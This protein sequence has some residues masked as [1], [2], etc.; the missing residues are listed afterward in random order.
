M[1]SALVVI[2]D[3]PLA[4]IVGISTALALIQPIGDVQKYLE[5]R[6]PQPFHHG[7][8]CLWI[9]LTE[10]VRE[11]TEALERAV[12]S[13]YSL[14]FS[15]SKVQPACVRAFELHWKA[16]RK[17]GWKLRTFRNTYDQWAKSQDWV[18]LVN[19]SKAPVSWRETNVGLSEEFLRKAVAVYFKKYNRKDGKRQAVFAIHRWWRTGRDVYGDERPVPGYESGWD[20]RNPEL[21]PSGWDYSNILRQV[22]ERALFTEPVR[23]LVHQ[24]TAA[25]KDE[26]PQHP[27]TRE[28]LLFLQEVTFDDVRTDFLIMD[29]VTGQPCELWLLVA[30]DTATAMVLGFVPHP[31]RARED[32]SDSHLGHLEMK[33]LVGFL[34]ER[35]PLPTYLCEWKVER[36][37]ATLPAGMKAALQEMLPNNIVV[38]YT[39]MIGGTSPNGYRESRKG[40][41]R[42][43][44]SHESHN[45]L[46]HTQSCYLD[47]QTGSNYALRPA[48]LKARCEEAVEIWE[49]SKLLPVHLRSEVKYP[50]LDL[51]QACEHLFR[52]SV[53]QNF[54]TNH[55]L[56]NFD[57][58]VEWF[59]PSEGQ[60]GKWKHQSTFDVTKHNGSKIRTRKRMEMPVERA[61]RLMQGHEWRR[62]S[63]DIIIALYRHT[64]SKLK[65]KASGE[66]LC[67]QILYSPPSPELRPPV[68]AIGYSHP[69]DPQFLHV[70]DGKGVILG[71][72]VRRDRIQKRDQQ[73]LQ[74]AMR[75]T[76][77]ALKAVQQYADELAAPDVERLDAMRVHNELVKDKAAEFINVAAVPDSAPGEITSPVAYA[78]THAPVNAKNKAKAV[79]ALD[80][81]IDEALSRSLK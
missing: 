60:H 63:P 46:Y 34:L 73:A 79:A 25:A 1:S 44:A 8:A 28:N 54:R 37:T 39:S 30:R 36:G 57:T 62:V 35:Y 49:A 13:V 59:D 70:T 18:D 80:D 77:A 52:F 38:S 74:Q 7:E 68:T 64:A 47:G 43:K 2:P 48:E 51:K 45:R 33:Q 58:I 19:F 76:D 12:K 78:L 40:N 26:L 27:G 56:E 14:V 23:A 42:G 5:D 15:G 75:Y 81:E 69:D 29:T 17:Y 10:P 21:L 20:K 3:A 50:L 9:T 41:S 32:G 53:E 55:R 16:A 67:R 11:E 61:I 31:S 66:I 24:G 22:K 72:W 65:I 71:T 4:P 6:K